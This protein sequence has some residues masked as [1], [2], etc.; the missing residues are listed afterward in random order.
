MLVVLTHQAYLDRASLPVNLSVRL[1]CRRLGLLGVLIG[2]FTSL[3]DY[4]LICGHM[5][6]HTPVPSILTS[7]FGSCGPF[8]SN[9]ASRRSRNVSVLVVLLYLSSSA[10]G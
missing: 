2:L 8:I 5:Q 4:T 9:S 7:I 3:D 6:L 1:Q 10:R